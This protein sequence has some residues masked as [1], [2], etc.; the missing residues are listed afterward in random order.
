MVAA[1]AWRFGKKDAWQIVRHQ[2]RRLPDVRTARS[3]LARA[4][5]PAARAREWSGGHVVGVST[6][7]LIGSKRPYPLRLFVP[8]P[9]GKRTVRSSIRQEFAARIAAACQS[10][11]ANEIAARVRCLREEEQAA[12]AALSSGW[13]RSGRHLASAI[14]EPSVQPAAK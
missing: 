5:K 11:P 2:A 3:D 9:S 13:R 6:F 1:L 7:R 8:V 10:G 14:A 4:S 12:L